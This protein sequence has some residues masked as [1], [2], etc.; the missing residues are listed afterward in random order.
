MF[1]LWLPG[2]KSQLSL[3]GCKTSA[4]CQ[5]LYAFVFLS[6]KR[7]P[8]RKWVTWGWKWESLVTK[9]QCRARVRVRLPHDIHSGMATGYY[10]VCSRASPPTPAPALCPVWLVGLLQPVDSHVKSDFMDHLIPP[11]FPENHKLY[12]FSLIC[13]RFHRRQTLKI[14]AA[15]FVHSTSK[16]LNVWEPG[17]P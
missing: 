2:L 10:V 9:I 5:P 3:I 7:G 6:V 8:Y 15:H 14:F 4:K 13:N 12:L 17:I 1:G 16:C 11:V